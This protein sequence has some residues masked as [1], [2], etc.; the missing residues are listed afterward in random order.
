MLREDGFVF[1]DGTVAR[2]SGNHYL[3]ST[4]TANVALVVQ[5]LER[6]RQVYRARRDIQIAPVTENWGQFAIAGPKSRVLLQR[7]LGEAIDL[8]NEAFPHLACAEFSWGGTIARLFRVSFSGE[9]GYE[10]AVPARYAAALVPALMEAGEDLGV[11]PYGLEAMDV[12][13]VEKGHIS[14]NEINGTTTSADLGFGELIS[15]KNGARSLRTCWPEGERGTAE[16][17]GAPASGGSV[18]VTR[19]RS[20]LRHFLGA[21]SDVWLH[22]PGAPEKR[23]GAHWR[24]GPRLRSGGRSQYGRGG[25][26]ASLPG[27]SR[28][29]AEKLT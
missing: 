20:R 18:R 28:A 6:E 5:H 1:D 13:R 25:D 14:G 29:A 2:L 21:L 24:A 3:M 15:K 16:C 12:L 8:S 4:T 23:A 22:R 17:R 19:E 9:L 27:P 26:C 11:T 7:L 10:L